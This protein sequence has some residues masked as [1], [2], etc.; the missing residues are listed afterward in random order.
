MLLHRD[1]PQTLVAAR[2]GPPL[3]VGLGEG[4]HFLASDVPALLP[5]TRDFVFLD[6]GDVVIVTPDER[7]PHRQR[8]AARSS[9]SPSASPG[10]R[11]RP[12]RAATATSC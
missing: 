5:Y 1:E 9:A 8:R 3:V 10:T 12:R 4:E 2:L 6:D 11:C 7:A